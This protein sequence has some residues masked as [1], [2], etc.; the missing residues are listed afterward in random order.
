M[1]EFFSVFN[2]KWLTGEF[3][4]DNDDYLEFCKKCYD[5]FKYNK[6]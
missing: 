3:L 6:G 1:C 4:E 5:D 2:E